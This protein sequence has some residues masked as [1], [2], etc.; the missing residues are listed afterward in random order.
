MG[1]GS[2]FPSLFLQARW[3]GPAVLVTYFALLAPSQLAGQAATTTGPA[4]AGKAAHQPAQNTLGTG[5]KE[6]LAGQPGEL[7]AQHVGKLKPA[8]VRPP[9]G[10]LRFPYLIPS[11]PEAEIAATR[12]DIYARRAELGIPLGVYHQLFD[13]DS[14]FEGVA[15]LRD[16]KGEYLRDSVRNFLELTAS[17]GYTPR[18]VDP[19][20]IFY[21]P[22]QCKPFLAQ[23]AFLA[24]KALGDFTWLEGRYYQNLRR[25]LDY[26]E[27]HRRGPHLLFQW[28]SAVESGV[29]NHPAVM[30]LP[31]NSVE[32]VDASVYMYREYLAMSLIADR[33]GKAEDSQSHR[34]KADLLARQIN[35]HLWSPGEQMYF[36][37]DTGSGELIK[38]QAWTNFLPLWAGIAPPERAKAMIEKHLLRAEAFWGQYGVPSVSRQEVIYNQ[39]RK[40]LYGSYDRTVSN[41]QGPIWVVANYL[42]MHGLLNYGYQQQ[43]VELA[44]KIVRLLEDDIRRTGGMHENYDAETGA[45]L[46]SPHFGSWNILAPQMV[47]EAQAGKDA[48][49]LAF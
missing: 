30:G 20:R 21:A 5:G 7:L 47:E 42:V 11:N 40:G 29:D 34:A 27:T 22:E 24:A 44:Q 41:W 31:P 13:W 38:L 8:L 45:G 16:G 6:S 4:P 32:A 12:G 3:L 46:W 9:A 39:A 14:F 1:N 48:T 35:Q 26:W 10:I 18:T 15:F 33:L 2:R 43:A 37:L 23:G 49:R 36:N 25:F 28:L 17:N 19:S